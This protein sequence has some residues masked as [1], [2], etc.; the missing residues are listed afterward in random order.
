METTSEG[1]KQWRHYGIFYDI[2]IFTNLSPEHLPSHGDSFEKYKAAKGKMFAVLEK[3]NHKIINGKKIEKI[4][5]AN[6]DNPHRDY[7]LGFRADKKITFGMNEGA[8]FVVKIS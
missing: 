6:Y 1:I 2:A 5:I 7:Y 8:D 4:I 3:S